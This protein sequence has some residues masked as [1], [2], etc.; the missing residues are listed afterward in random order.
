MRKTLISLLAGLCFFVGARAEDGQ[1][2]VKIVGGPYL[3]NVT[4]TSFTVCFTTNV[5]AVGWVELAPEDGTHFYNCS[6][7]KYWDLRGKGRK[8][9]GTYHQITVSNLEPGT[10]YRYRPMCRGVIKADNRN[11]IIYDGG[12]GRNILGKAQPCRVTTQKDSYDKVTFATVNDMHESDSLFQCLMKDARGKYDFVVFNGDMTSSVD[13]ESDIWKHYM[14]SASKLF[15]DETPLYLGRGNHE[16]R[17]N[18]AIAFAG[19]FVT[20]TGMTYYAFNYGQFFF[21]MLDGGEDKP[22]DDIRNLDIMITEDY[23]KAESQWLEQVLQTPECKNATKRIA[24]CHMPPFIKE[25][26]GG[27]TINRYLVPALNAANFDLMICGHTHRYKTWPAGDARMGTN[28]PIVENAN[29]TR[30]VT[31]VTPQAIKL[32]F[33]APDGTASQKPLSFTK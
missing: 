22:M 4:K 28:F 8:P 5:P 23:V 24:F 20:P 18:D 2:P 25:W 33:Y 1:P 13:C 14:T 29:R 17:G 9:I 7:P 16:N 10:T 12:Y 21:L 26:Y 3:Q 27:A 31:T 19:Y 11:S 32:E 30:M 6:R 15:A